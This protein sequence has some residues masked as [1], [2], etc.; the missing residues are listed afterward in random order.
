MIKIEL[1]KTVKLK[2]D[3]PTGRTA[4]YQGDEEIVDISELRIVRYEGDNGYYLL[5]FNRKGEEVTDTYH[6]TIHQAMKQAEFEFNVKVDE[7]ET[8]T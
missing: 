1:L 2:A 8:N 7:W 5:Y 6:D 3:H 4:H